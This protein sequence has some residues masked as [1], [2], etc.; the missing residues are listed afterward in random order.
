MKK[1]FVSAGLVAVGAAGF[2]TAFAAGI[3][4]SPKAWN[5]SGTLRGFYDDNSG[6]ASQKKGSFGVE[7]SPTISL[8]VPLA[9]TDFGIRYI[10]GFYYYQERQDVYKTP[11]DQTHQLEVWLDHAFTE[12]WHANVSDTFSMGQEPELLDT[13]VSATPYRIAGDNMANHANLTLSTEWSRLF[14]TSLHYANSFYDYESSGATVV[15]GGVPTGFLSVNPASSQAGYQSLSGGGASRAGLL[16]R[17]EQNVSLDLQWTLRPETTAFIGYNFSLANYTGSEPIAVFNYIDAVPSARSLVYKSDSRDSM[18][19]SAYLGLSH[20]FTAAI[21]GSARG[22]VSYT[23]SYNDPLQKSTSLSPYA[24]LS[25]SYTYIPG[26]YVQIGFTHDINSTDVASLDAD[27]G[28]TQYQESSVLYAS[29]NHRFSPKLL[30]TAIGR[31]VN[32]TFHGG[33]NNNVSDETYGLG[34]N[35][36]YQ[37]NRHFSADVGYNYDVLESALQGRGYVRNRVYLGLT[38]SY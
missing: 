14:S 35:F 22:G 25:V 3:D 18:S 2:Q 33:A 10:Y 24:D 19:H 12:R 32:S 6:S 5:V 7:V 29:V 38:A 16:N 15:P 17:M 30:G 20:Q 26:S 11:Y 28:I 4:I 34:V 13:G 36:S 21:Y 8:H 37:I 27:G 9:Q 1:I 23:D 31:F